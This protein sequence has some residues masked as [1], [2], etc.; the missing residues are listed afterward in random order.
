MD[1]FFHSNTFNLPTIIRDGQA[2]CKAAAWKENGK[3]E[4]E[5]NNIVLDLEYAGFASIYKW[6]FHD[7]MSHHPK[8]GGYSIELKLQ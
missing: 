3:I 4:K 8:G 1:T 2:L 7:Y 5:I 6:A